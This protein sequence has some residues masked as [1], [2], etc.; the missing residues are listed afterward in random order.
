MLS[1]REGNSVVLGFNFVIL[2]F[3]SHEIFLNAHF[4]VQISSILIR[5]FYLQGFDLTELY[6]TNS[7]DNVEFNNIFVKE[8]CMLPLVSYN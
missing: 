7:S 5:S 6:F 1:T 3:V 8:M 2:R 4:S